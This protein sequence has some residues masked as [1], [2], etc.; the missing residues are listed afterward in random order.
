MK[1]KL[2]E[3]SVEKSDIL[4]YNKASE[5]STWDVRH[6]CYFEPAML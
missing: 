1:L 2:L 6:S 5:K 4:E 3:F